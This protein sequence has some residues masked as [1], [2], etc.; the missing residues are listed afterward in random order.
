MEKPANLRAKRGVWLA[1]FLVG[2]LSPARASSS[3]DDFGPLVRDWLFL[4]L[5]SAE[6]EQ[7]DMWPR[8]SAL[9]EVG[10]EAGRTAG[11]PGIWRKAYIK[12]SEQSQKTKELN[13]VLLRQSTFG[14]GLAAV[15]IGR[16]SSYCRPSL[17]RALI[18]LLKRISKSSSDK[19]SLLIHI[20]SVFTSVYSHKRRVR[21]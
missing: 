13:F 10:A 16:D 8:L 4:F 5:L 6:A 19:S 14:G 18:N 7:K 9:L 21:G 12:L 20:G 3:L 17:G 1:Y 11:T 15:Y 2:V